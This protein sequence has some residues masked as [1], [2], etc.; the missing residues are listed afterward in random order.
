MFYSMKS[1][2]R[3]IV[4]FSD[5]S[6]LHMLY[7]PVLYLFEKLMQFVSS[8]SVFKDETTM[9]Q[10]FPDMKERGPGRKRKR[11]PKQVGGPAKR[12]DLKRDTTKM[13]EAK[14][15]SSKAN[16]KRNSTGNVAGKAG[17]QRQG[18]NRLSSNNASRSRSKRFVVT[19]N[20]LKG[21]CALRG[22]FSPL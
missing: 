7:L 12:E 20:V 4:R 2:T 14:K 18:E 19:V 10:F 16:A 9:A 13:E 15:A 3:A 11:G 8:F 21:V 17:G 5:I 1:I 22:Y 6:T